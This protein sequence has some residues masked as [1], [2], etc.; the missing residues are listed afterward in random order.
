MIV[1]ENIWNEWANWSEVA[2]ADPS[3][4]LKVKIAGNNRWEPNHV[5]E[6]LSILL[7]TAVSTHKEHN[8]DMS[9]LDFGCG[10]GRNAPMLRRYF[11]RVVGVDIPE[12]VRRINDQE[13]SGVAS[14][15]DVIYDD[16]DAVVRKEKVHILYDSVVWQHIISVPYI[17]ELLSKLLLIPSLRTVVSLKAAG[18][19]EPVAQ[20]LL[21]EQGWQTVLA[22]D[23]DISFFGHKHN[24]TVLRR[25][26]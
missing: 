10:L 26:F 4:D 23:D 22:E 2:A 11:P 7:R 1:S 13:M 18:L 16:L 25:P 8:V 24:L 12:M 9:V 3:A 15:Y 20:R 5:G 14:L 6:T 21:R 17:T 19:P